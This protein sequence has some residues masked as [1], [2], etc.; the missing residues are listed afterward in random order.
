MAVYGM[1][2]II[3]GEPLAG[4]GPTPSLAVQIFWLFFLGG[5]LIACVGY[6]LACLAEILA[7]WVQSA[8]DS[9]VSNAPRWRLAART[10]TVFA[11]GLARSSGASAAA[12]S[13]IALV[14][15]WCP[16]GN[17]ISTRAHHASDV[18]Y[19]AVAKARAATRKRATQ[20]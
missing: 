8:A 11:R 9:A 7:D 19:A 18:A 6:A 10:N 12:A 20:K 16:L 17:A 15:G 13:V 3:Q 2:R 5:G 1:C 4:D 14:F